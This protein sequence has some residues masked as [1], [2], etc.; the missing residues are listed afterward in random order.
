[1]KKYWVGLLF[2][3]FPLLATAAESLSF[4][5]PPG[6]YSV[7]FLGN[8]FGVVDGVLHGT[9]SQIMGSM[10]AVFNAAV[11]ALGGIIIMYTLIVGTMNTAHEGQMLGQKW[12][13]IWIPVRSTLGLALLVPKAS[14]YC[15]MQI[16]IMWIVVQGV[17][18][19]DKV[20][21]A[22]LEYLNRG[23]VI[24]QAQMSSDVILSAGATGTNESP[25]AH[26]AGTIL[27]GQV[28]M[29]GIQRQLEAQ[30]DSMIAAKEK[31]AGPCYGNDKGDTAYLCN[32]VV[33]D[34]MGT[35]NAVYVQNAN[36]GR[37]TFEVKM[38]NF[39]SGTPYYK[40]NGVCGSIKWNAIL[41]EDNTKDIQTY[42]TTVN[43][44]DLATTSL[45]RAIAI[46][47]MYVDLSTTARTM[48]NNN[49]QINRSN[50]GNTNNFSSVAM[51][52]FGVPILKSGGVCATPDKNCTQWGPD[53]SSTAGTLL[54][55]TE[56]LG[57]LADYNG[58]M[59]PTLNLLSQANQG[60]TASDARK[61]IRDA[62]AAGWI[63]AGSYFFE[64]V[65]LNGSA[66][67]ST[68]T[69]T[70][71]GLENSNFS[72]DTMAGAFE[73]GGC[74][75]DYAEL[76][77]LFNKTP[78]KVNAVIAL[79]G[80]G[81]FPSFSSTNH[82]SVTGAASSTAYGYL[83][84]AV[85][86]SLPN[87]PGLEPPKFLPS[88]TVK[89][90]GT[91]PK[92]DKMSA[93]CDV[94]RHPS[95]IGQCIGAHLYNLIV[96]KLSNIVFQ[97]LLDGFNYLMLNFL[98]VPL[99]AVASAFQNGVAYIQQP[100]VNPIVALAQMGRYYIDFG[101]NLWVVLIGVSVI[102]GWMPGF[103]IVL[104]LITP[105]IFTWLA[106]MVVLGFTTAYYI[107]FL[108]YMLFIFGVIAWLMAVI[109]AMV[110]GPV[111]AL[112]ITHPEGEGIL[113]KGEQAIMILMNVFL[114]PA[115]MIIGYIAGIALCYVGVWIMNSGFQRI[116][117]FITQSPNSLTDIWAFAFSNFFAILIYTMFYLS[118]VEKSFSLI[119]ILPDKV[120]RWIG[121]QGE[122]IGAETAQW[123][124]KAKQQLET[125]G[126]ETA[127]AGAAT[128]KFAKGQ[129]AES[130]GKLAGFLGGKGSSPEGG[131]GGGG[132]SPEGG[133][134]GA[135]GS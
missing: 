101:M 44:N 74:T 108:P 34:F 91:V 15:L 87:Q 99:S 85:M 8:L 112:G 71:S 114:R 39:D 79:I 103:G 59:Q 32:N 69:D 42:V 25:I 21:N 6:D 105:I 46:Q 31:K 113:G 130:A 22:A 58:I 56:L 83:N 38:P 125:T 117:N 89:P 41:N 4:T 20:W 95:R 18:A 37:K 116:S 111:V 47:Q 27:A 77:L 78:D 52:Q 55:G 90:T 43:Q 35:V 100:G 132:S 122:Q 72:T 131:G 65:K 30:R 121:G 64:L 23:G 1:M 10:F 86:I 133:G 66:L 29:Y 67:P 110:A 49:P 57:A 68:K 14:G 33:P 63:Q 124:E 2:L 13:S 62:E 75:G 126:K 123:G 3:L 17:G 36:P 115:M 48:V 12:S 109:E 51:S 53:P 81:S 96:V 50:A 102:F 82:P 107:P 127:S 92:L 106:A 19:A 135:K 93:N 94:A 118:I 60:S 76:C 24:I 98:T 84:N 128:G 119:H 54:N 5:P 120:L 61:F 26:G 11:L 16:F 40:L 80:S 129:A 7:I 45:S 9:G 104:G 88:I 134:D 73:S 97:G 70:G 28:C